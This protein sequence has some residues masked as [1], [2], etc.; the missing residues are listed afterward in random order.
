MRTIL[1]ALYLIAGIAMLAIPVIQLILHW[2][3]GRSSAGDLARMGNQN[4]V[5]IGLAVLAVAGVYF[6]VNPEANIRVDLLLAIPL[7]IIMIVLWGLLKFR[8]SRLRR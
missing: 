7:G 4:N 3:V 2:R 6:F 1:T 5:L 8:L